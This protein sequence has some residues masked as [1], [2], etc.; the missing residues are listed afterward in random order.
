VDTLLESQLFGHVRGSFTGATDTR[1]GLFEYANGWTVFL[2]EVG[3]TSPP[4]QAKLLRV[5]QNREIQRVG[6]PEVRLVNVSLIAA[7]NRDLRAEVLSGRF[8]EDLYYRLSSIQIRVPSLAERLDDIALR[9]QYFLKKY[10][11]AY[12]KNIAGLM[13]RAQAIMLQHAWPGKVRELENMISSACITAMGDFLDIPDLPD[14]LQHRGSGPGGR[15]D[16]RP[17]SLDEVRK[18][19]IRRVLAMC[20]GNR[21]R[22]AQVL[23][24]GRTSLYWYLKEDG[25][26]QTLIA[27]SKTA[28]L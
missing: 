28:G 13:R 4:M 7:T 2:D 14:Q 19:H 10:N 17:L 9:V 15:D 27:R 21:L 26:D 25:Y 22:A 1:P 11:G 18:Q 20:K 23:G 5:I 24:I 3:E 12:G 6:S 8:R 16:W